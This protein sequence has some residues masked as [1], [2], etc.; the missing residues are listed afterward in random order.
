M[1]Y[2][3]SFLLFSLFT[4]SLSATLRVSYNAYIPRDSDFSTEYGPSLGLGWFLPGDLI[5]LELEGGYLQTDG[6]RS[7]EEGGI[8]GNADFRQRT[9]PLLAHASLSVPLG[10]DRTRLYGGVTAGAAYLDIRGDIEVAG[11]SFSDSVSDV[12]FV[13]GGGGG[14][15]VQLASALHLD[16]QYRYLSFSDAAFSGD[17]LPETIK[18]SVP[19]AHRASIGLM[20][21]F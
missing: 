7:F 13:F 4:S 8:G 14:L 1:R 19:D 6:R 3:F 2:L 16:L 10:S 18:V 11:Q 21:K 20:L 12:V 15:L 17:R 5:F 9:I